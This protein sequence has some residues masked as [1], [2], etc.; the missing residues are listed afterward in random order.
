MGLKSL[1]FW[2][3]GLHVES[4]FSLRLSSLIQ[5]AIFVKIIR[6]QTPLT[7]LISDLHLTLSR[8]S[9]SRH[10]PPFDPSGHGD[11]CVRQWWLSDVVHLKQYWTVCTRE[12]GIAFH[13]LLK[14]QICVLKRCCENV[15][16]LT[17]IFVSEWSMSEMINGSVL[18]CNTDGHGFKSIGHI[19]V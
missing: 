11:R 19:S 15:W 2:R 5:N 17:P 14:Q 6:N 10:V 1:P 8:T 12:G 7:T 16:C 4:N 13:P 9:G 18:A 3:N